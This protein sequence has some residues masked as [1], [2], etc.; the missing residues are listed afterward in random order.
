MATL[1]LAMDIVDTV[2][3]AA[4][5]GGFIHVDAAADALI[6]AHPEADVTRAEVAEVL[7]EEGAATGTIPP[8]PAPVP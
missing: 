5:D 7:R 6:E 4:Q 8:K 1:P 2:E 3:H